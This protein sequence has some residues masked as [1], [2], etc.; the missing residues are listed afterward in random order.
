VAYHSSP[1]KPDD[2]SPVKKRKAKELVPPDM[3]SEKPASSN[4]DTL[5]K[6]AEAWL[7]EKDEM[8]KLE[9]LIG[10]TRCKIFTP[11]GLREVVDPCEFA[12]CV[13]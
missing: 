6:D 8:G 13:R 7:I 12:K 2:P 4:I 3:G 5:L 11:E 1:V 9:G 10:K